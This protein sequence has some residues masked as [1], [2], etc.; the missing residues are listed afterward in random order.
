MI[1]VYKTPSVLIFFST[2]LTASL[3]SHWDTMWELRELQDI[4][5]L[6]Q[7]LKMKDDSGTTIRNRSWNQILSLLIYLLHN[8]F[9]NLKENLSRIGFQIPLFLSRMLA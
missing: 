2:M 9:H 7:K 3:W 6:L 8:L 1:S 4:K 5:K